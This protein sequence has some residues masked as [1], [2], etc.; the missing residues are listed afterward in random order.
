MSLQMSACLG[1]WPI[2]V[3]TA[4]R[5]KKLRPGA[6][7]IPLYQPEACAEAILEGRSKYLAFAKSFSRRVALKIGGQNFF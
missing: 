3:A 6:Y 5:I 4:P 7:L 2:P 1:S